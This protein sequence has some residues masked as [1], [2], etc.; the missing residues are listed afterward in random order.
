MSLLLLLLL[1]LHCWAQYFRFTLAMS[2][3][4]F[5]RIFYVFPHFV[6]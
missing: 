6:Q 5:F 4:F 1:L 2:Y 3:D